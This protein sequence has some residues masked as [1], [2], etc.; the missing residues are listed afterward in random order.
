MSTRATV[1]RAGVAV[2][3][4]PRLR[5]VPSRPALIARC[6]RRRLGRPV[7]GEEP[8][9]YVQTTIALQTRETLTKRGLTL[10]DVLDDCARELADVF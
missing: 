9:V 6:S 5:T 3:V 7:V 2:A 10:A 4:R 8:R 1:A